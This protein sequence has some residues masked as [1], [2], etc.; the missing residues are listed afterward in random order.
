MAR[1]MIFNSGLHIRFWGDAVKY[2]TYVLNRS[3]SRSNPGQKSPL[4]LLEGRPPSLLNIVA[5]GS[6]CMVH[7]DS[8]RQAFKKRA[9]RGIILGIPEET[10]GYVVYLKEDQKVINTQHEKHIESLSNA[11]NATLLELPSN[12]QESD[13]VQNGGAVTPANQPGNHATNSRVSTR[14]PDQSQPYRRLRDALAACVESLEAI[15]DVDSVCNISIGEPLTYKA[16]KSKHFKAWQDAADVELDTLRTNCTWIAVEK[17][18]SARPLHSK[19]V[20]KTKIDADGGI[21]HFKARLVVCRNEQEAGVNYNDTFVPVLDL[22]TA[23]TIL[24]LSV[25]WHCPARHGD[26]TAAYTKAAVES[27]ADVY[28]YPPKGMTLGQSER[29]S[30]LC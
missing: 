17:P 29:A 9:T 12:D 21:K 18:A 2:V 14:T 11:Q 20:F 16:A 30:R 23:R 27:D 15:D 7:R 24:A 4:E 28:M 26:V 6:T 3:P 10:K 1:C 22:A 13:N 8:Y 19:W 5:F 25:I